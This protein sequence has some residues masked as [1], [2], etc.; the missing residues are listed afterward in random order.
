M[1]ASSIC[2][3]DCNRIGKGMAGYVDD[4]LGFILQ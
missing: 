2:V 3:P 4:R 1:S